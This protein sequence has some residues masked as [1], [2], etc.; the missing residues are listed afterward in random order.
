MQKD[1]D[2][3]N[4]ILQLMGNTDNG[5]YAVDGERRL[6]LWNQAAEE[7]LGYPASEVLGK[8]CYEVL[9]GTDT[10][11]NIVC[12]GRCEDIE[13]AKNQG[14]VPGYDVRIKAKDG[15]DVWINVTNIPVPSDL[16]GQFALVH[17]FRNVNAAR[18]M[19]QFGHKLEVL[20]QEFADFRSDRQVS[21]RVT[22]EALAKLT[23]REREVLALLA[24]GASAKAIAANLSISISTARKHI[25][26][27]L[28][29]LGVHSTLEAAIAAGPYLSR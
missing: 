24:R 29:K 28:N 12:H 15:R 23:S 5:V 11:G 1:R 2:Q 4:G 25:Q 10:M 26:N 9:A 17:I 18:D 8:P 7:I 22:T 6:V 19:E 16:N 27:I 3:T 20:L 14:L 13:L 21:G